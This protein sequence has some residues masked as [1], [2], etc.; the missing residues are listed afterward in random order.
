M[1]GIFSIAPLIVF[2]PFIGVLINAFFGRQ[3]M[4]T[5]QSKAPGVIASF[6]AGLSFLVAVLLFVGLLGSPQ[7]AE[8]PLLTWV[9]I[10]VAGRSLVIPW[11]F[12][13]DTLSVVMML[14]VTGVGTLI[15]IYAIG[16]MDLDIDVKA[17]EW[18]LSVEDSIDLKQRR[19]SR[20]FTYL[21]LFL[22]SMLILVTAN[23]FLMMFVG[24]ELVGLCSFLL[25][26]FWYDDPHVGLANAGAAQKAFI[27]NRVGDF[28]MLM[29]IFFI[30]W[31]FGS[32]QFTE[33]FGRAECMIENTQAECLALSAA[34]LEEEFLVPQEEGEGEEEAGLVTLVSRVNGVPF[35]EGDE[36]GPVTTEVDLFG[37]SLTLTGAVTIITLFLLLGAAGKSAQ[38]PLF[39]WLPDA[40][41]GPTPVSA[42]IHAATMVT[43]GIYM[44]TR[45]N[46]LY[47][48]APVSAES[49]AIVGAVTALLAATIA[50]AQFDIK[51]VLAYSTISQLGFMVAAVGLGGYVAGIFHLVTHAFFKA[52]LF[53]G[54]GS[55][56][57]GMERGMVGDE[58]AHMYDHGHHHDAHHNDD[59][60]DDH[61]DHHVDPQDMRNM[62]GLLGRMPVTGW[63]YIIG[64]LALAGIFPLAGFWSKDEILLDANNEMLFAYILLSVAAFLTAFY[65]GRQ[66]FMVF[67]GEPRTDAARDATESPATMTVP[68]VILG[69]LSVFGGLIN[70]PF[71]GF[72]QLGHWLEESVLYAHIPKF[73]PVVAVISTVVAVAAIAGAYAI[74]GRKPLT[75]EGTDPLA[76]RLGAAFT[77]LNNKWYIDEIYHMVFIQPYRRLAD[78]FANVIDWQFLHDYIHDN[79]IGETFRGGSE[80]LSQPVDRGLIDGLVNGIARVIGVSSS[81][82]RRIQ[83]GYVRNYA[84]VIGIG[85]FLVLVFIAAQFLL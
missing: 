36:V 51:K 45:S 10:E 33:V 22:G 2:I 82:A 64:A 23:N 11:T 70:L 46:V 57:Q 7:G 15:H 24:W 25:I 29:A 21:N 47:H 44:I 58:L 67:F 75:D 12:R 84:L 62:G 31:T 79:I 30:F 59:H 43:A 9:D 6:I 53:K 20:F 32:V 74:Y 34:E 52:L 55:V 48:L 4:P 39:V 76:D 18:G 14:V 1:A 35:A 80:L 73:N 37:M 40:M 41:A 13:V 3:L 5:P 65:M 66:V 77:F 17:H 60:H 19:F 42:L 61:H 68:L 83:T 78:F 63:T 8:I 54:S 16:Y 81:G 26:G 50:V 85:V 38:V 49:V 56:I 71:S 69:A 28:G 72:H 27:A